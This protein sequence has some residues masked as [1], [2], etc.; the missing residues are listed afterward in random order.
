MTARFT[1]ELQGSVLRALYAGLTLVEAAEQVGVAERTLRNWLSTG[2]S[3]PDS[4]HGRFAVAVDEARDVAARADMTL[5]EFRGHLNKAVRAGSV[6]A[7][8]V[9]LELHEREQEDG[10]AGP[11]ASL[12]SEESAIQR[13]A[14]RRTTGS[15]TST[16]NNHTRE[17]N[18]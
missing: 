17:V 12:D 10:E 1:P 6:A 15:A 18:A 2:R 3:N 14:R 11:F 8:K 9:W 4:E 16:F 7:M 13:L 5:D